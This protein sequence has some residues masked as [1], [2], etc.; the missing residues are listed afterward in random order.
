[1]SDTPE[2]LTPAQES[3]VSALLCLT[4]IADAA[5]AAKVS[6]RTAY[7]WL[8]LPAIQ[9]ELSK[10]RDHAFTQGL[11]K[12]QSGIDLAIS[13]LQ[14]NMISDEPQSTQ[15]R[16]AQIWLDQALKAHE[17]TDIKAQLAELQAL[18]KER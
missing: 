16:A 11:N 9:A 2:T 17:M 14:R 4:T 12:L 5:A 6:E 10:A 8:K 1:M 13:T 18:V 15:V 7:R 3:F